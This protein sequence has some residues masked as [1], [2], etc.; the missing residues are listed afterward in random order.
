M[1]E[2]ARVAVSDAQIDA[3]IA[4]ARKYAKYDQR[5]VSA[6][7]VKRAD[8]LRLVF[9]SG[10][11]LSIPRRLIQ[12]LG[13]AKEKELGRIQIL[14]DGTGLLWPLLEISHYVPSLLQGVYGT[15]KWMASLQKQRR[16][17][18]LLGSPATPKRR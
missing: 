12:G 16:R 11:V 9:D 5:V 13:E 4:R 8:R 17:L 18:K 15:E 1:P 6:D 10:A 7:Y 2:P 3:A 14:S